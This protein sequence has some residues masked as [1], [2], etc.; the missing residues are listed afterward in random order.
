[1][2]RCPR[3]SRGRRKPCHTC[4]TWRPRPSSSSASGFP[5]ARR[6][7]VRWSGWCWSRSGA[8]GATCGRIRRHRVLVHVGWQVTGDLARRLM[9]SVDPI[10]STPPARPPVCQGARPG[11]PAGA[12]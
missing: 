11:S 10:I 1:M 2:K 6:R 5:S 12:G 3:S 7:P 9:D 4:R 8:T